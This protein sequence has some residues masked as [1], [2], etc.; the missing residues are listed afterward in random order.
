MTMA[1][2]STQIG[3][4]EPPQ[5]TVREWW[6]ANALTLSITHWRATYYHA[7]TWEEHPW[8][9][10]IAGAPFFHEWAVECE[11][12][13]RPGSWYGSY[14]LQFPGN[15]EEEDVSNRA[16]RCFTTEQEALQSTLEP[17]RTRRTR[18]LQELR[19]LQSRRRSIERRIKAVVARTGAVGDHNCRPA[20]HCL[21]GHNAWFHRDEPPR[22]CG[23]EGCSCQG[24]LLCTAPH[25]GTPVALTT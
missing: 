20:P 9:A 19:E 16:R 8:G 13:N 17:L 22:S 4:D 5:G 21:C 25:K 6:E 1:D 15:P 23:A 3:Q 7:C 10:S 14:R 24:Y 2:S 12:A 11:S 18:L